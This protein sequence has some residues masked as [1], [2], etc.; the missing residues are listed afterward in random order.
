MQTSRSRNHALITT[1]IIFNKQARKNCGSPAGFNGRM[2]L[3]PLLRAVDAAKFLNKK[4]QRSINVSR[5]SS[6]EMHRW[7]MLLASLQARL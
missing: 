1:H 6:T 5:Y 2:L 7:N 3:S 4:H